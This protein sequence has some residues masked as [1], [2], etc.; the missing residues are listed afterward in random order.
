MMKWEIPIQKKYVAEDMA[1]VTVL[2]ILE[3]NQKN[4]KFYV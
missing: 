4:W 3:A 1:S 2:D